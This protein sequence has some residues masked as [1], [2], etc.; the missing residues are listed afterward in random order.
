MTPALDSSLTKVFAQK[1]A[2]RPQAELALKQL[3]PEANP[4][5]VIEEKGGWGFYKDKD[6]SAMG[7]GGLSFGAMIFII[8]G[9]FLQEIT[10]L[11]LGAI[12]L[13]KSSFDYI[14][15]SGSVEIQR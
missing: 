4:A 2:L 11:K 13:E 8:A 3:V 10:K 6:L 7:Y 1:F 14:S 5:V 15:N 9:F 12:E